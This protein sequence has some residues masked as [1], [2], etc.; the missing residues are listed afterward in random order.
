M[1]SVGVLKF[2]NYLFST[3]SCG[4]WYLISICFDLSWNWKFSLNFTQ[5]WLS[6]NNMIGLYIG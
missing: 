3:F 1:F 5:D 6:Q 4:K 2:P